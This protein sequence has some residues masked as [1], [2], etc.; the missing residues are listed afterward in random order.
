VTSYIE[1]LLDDGTAAAALATLTAA[2]TSLANIF[3]AS[4]YWAKGAD[5]ASASPL[6]LGTDGNYFDVTGTT[7]FTAMTAASPGL[8]GVQFDGALLLTHHATTLNLPGAANITTVA[9][10]R[11]IFFVTAAN[12]V[13][14]LAFITGDGR[15]VTGLATGAEVITGTEA[16]KA[17]TP[18]TLE[19]SLLVPACLFTFTPG[20]SPA[21]TFI[22]GNSG[23]PSV[24]QNGTG[25]YTVTLA[26]DMA[27]AAYVVLIMG[28]HSA[29][30]AYH[31]VSLA[32]GSFDVLS[33]TTAGSAADPSVKY[34]VAVYGPVA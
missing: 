15:M 21:V 28:E 18:A 24:A 33:T 30:L 2:G 6:V 12:T 25:D 10:D 31:T 7:G 29:S 13:H 22:G 11:M 4:Q 8:F 32:A 19:D 27:S 23:A 16:A 3:T 17:I 1:T 34:S 5:L 14:V 26:G 20:S 9:G